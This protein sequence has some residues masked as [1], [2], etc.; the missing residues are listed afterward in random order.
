M[1][2][3]ISVTCFGDAKLAVS[4]SDVGDGSSKR[5]DKENLLQLLLLFFF[6]F[7]STTD[8][9]CIRLVFRLCSLVPY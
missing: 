4:T 7:F 6:L 8:G 3:S 1:G 2:N 9:K 5:N